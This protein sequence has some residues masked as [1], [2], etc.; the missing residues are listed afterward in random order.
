MSLSE[1]FIHK[2][3]GR[4]N[5]TVAEL[6]SRTHKAAGRCHRLKGRRAFKRRHRWNL[7]A[8]RIGFRGTPLRLLG[9]TA[10]TVSTLPVELPGRRSDNR[11]PPNVIGKDYDTPIG[12][13]PFPTTKRRFEAKLIQ[14]DQ[15]AEVA[16]I[17][18]RFFSHD[19]PPGSVGAPPISGDAGSFAF[20][21]WRAATR[22]KMTLT[23]LPRC[24][25][26]RLAPS[27]R[28]HDVWTIPR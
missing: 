25:L 27:E 16:R 20:I 5:S 6:F 1:L 18:Q 24:L 4:R 21:G 10:F 9:H 28:L 19:E 7:D 3:A 26:P 14:G 12:K 22:A 13:G 11:R 23:F 17:A 8:T 15:P 2:L